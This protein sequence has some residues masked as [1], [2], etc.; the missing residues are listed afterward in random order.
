MPSEA[1]S[2]AWDFTPVYDLLSLLQQH[3]VATPTDQQDYHSK[4]ATNIRDQT[5]SES[6]DNTASSNDDGVALGNFAKLWDYLGVQPN[7]PTAS[8]PP[9]EASTAAKKLDLDVYASDGALYYPPSSK[10]VQW[11]DEAEYGADLADTQPESPPEQGLTKT[12]RKK[13]NRRARKEL[14]RQTLDEQAQR[15][16]ELQRRESEDEAYTP[17]VG[18]A[19]QAGVHK[20]TNGDSAE[21]PLIIQPEKKARWS[22]ERRLFRNTHARNESSEASLPA[23]HDLKKEQL[24]GL[25]PAQVVP[26]RAAAKSFAPLTPDAPISSRTRSQAAHKP[27]AVP[28][29]PSRPIKNNTIHDSLRKPWPTARPYSE[30]QQSAALT[31]PRAPPQKA[32]LLPGPPSQPQPNQ[33]KPPTKSRH[34]IRPLTLHNSL[35]RNWSMLLKLMRDFPTDRNYLL[36]PL[37]LS[38]NKPQPTGIHVFVDA[39]NILIGYH[40]H[41]KRARGISRFAR[42]PRIYPSFHAL[43][44]LLERRRPVAKRILVGSTPEVP[45]FEEARQVG[46]ETCVLDKVYKARE[47]TERQRRFALRDAGISS[48]GGGYASGS[49]SEGKGAGALPAQQ[50]KWVEQAVDEVIHLKMLESLVDTPVPIV[51]PPAAPATPTVATPTPSSGTRLPNTITPLPSTAPP[52]PPRPTMILATGDA[53]EAEYSSGFMKMVER[54]LAKGWNVEVAAWGASISVAYRNL[55]RRS[56]LAGRFRVVEL[57]AYAEELFPGEV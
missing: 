28:Q 49:D 32:T 18:S 5:L 44:L 26:L 6:T 10:S 52:A 2:Q 35:D 12:Q 9:F 11:R 33:Q 13:K 42:I 37:Q 23:S 19:Q 15:E 56:K 31:A 39:S 38:Y 17:P 1:Q 45:A 50:P 51:A 41:L 30:L 40:D 22:K 21:D 55:E 29:T 53:A 16:E 8:V 57:D 3:N 24:E 14:E 36:S 25:R 7:P 46:Y 54:A 34:E 4:L 48:G 47:L 43:A 20:A 27:S